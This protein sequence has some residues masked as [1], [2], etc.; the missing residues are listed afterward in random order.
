MRSASVPETGSAIP[1]VS[2]RAR[3][4]AAS[5]P[6]T[7]TY[8]SL[9][10][11]PRLF[12][13]RAVTLWRL[14]TS[15]W[16]RRVT[17][18]AAAGVNRR[19]RYTDRPT[20]A[21]VLKHS[22]LVRGGRQGQD[23]EESSHDEQGHPRD[24]VHPP[25]DWQSREGDPD[26]EEAEE[27]PCGGHGLD[28]GLGPKGLSRPSPPVI[29]A[30]KCSYRNLPHRRVWPIPKRSRRWGKSGRRRSSRRS[31]ASPRWSAASAI[32]MNSSH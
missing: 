22:F 29:T 21:S 14:T 5:L 32:R 13:S 10:A 15:S 30:R 6:S 2:S 31:S 24:P 12:A 1:F 11:R 9:P 18:S 23:H 28:E 25:G 27:G 19:T 26:A 8:R 16:R 7:R 4:R 3:A 17:F 20:A